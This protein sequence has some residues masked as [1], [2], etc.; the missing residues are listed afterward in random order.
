[1]QYQTIYR[2]AATVLVA[3]TILVAGCATNDP[4]YVNEA[5]VL[6][7][8]VP[9]EDAHISDVHVY[10]DGDELVIYGKV[11]RAA[12][13]CCDAVRGH[14]D[15]GVVSRDGLVLDVI[16][17]LYSPRNIPK[18]RS[19]SSRFTATLPYIPPDGMILAIVYQS[20]SDAADSFL[21]AGGRFVCERNIAMLPGGD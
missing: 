15:I 3:A 8:C 14:V 10:E 19:R 5:S 17:V 13:N 9:S 20:S 4:A 11:K 7:E 12:N 21:Y 6:V 18:V 16:S 1:M 2:V